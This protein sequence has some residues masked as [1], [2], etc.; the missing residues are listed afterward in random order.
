MIWLLCD[1]LANESLS[2]LLECWSCSR[3]YIGSGGVSRDSGCPSPSDRSAA[4][5]TA[6]ETC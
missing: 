3:C 5:V 1:L 2:Y 4:K 6:N